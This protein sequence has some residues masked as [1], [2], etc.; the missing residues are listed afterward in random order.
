MK[1]FFSIILT[2]LLFS[3]F[4]KPNDVQHVIVMNDGK[5]K[6]GLIDSMD[7]NTV[8]Y[9][10]IDEQKQIS[11]NMQEIYYIYED[12]NKSFYFSPSLFDRLDYAEERG[13]YVIT[14]Q[15][16]TIFYNQVKFNRNLKD[17]LALLYL[18]D[19]GFSTIPLLDLHAIRVDK[20]VI[21]HSVRKGA[22]ATSAAFLI[23][24]YFHLKDSFSN[25]TNYLPNFVQTENG[26]QFQSIT[27]IF[28]V[29]TMGWMI[30]D[31]I[32]DKRTNYIRP[33]EREKQFPRSMFFFSLKRKI[34]GGLRNQW[35]QI[36]PKKHIPNILAR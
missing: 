10:D 16:D 23:S 34:K 9:F 19:G 18:R 33:L 2:I 29:T 4:G 24:V 1:H 35:K 21:E 7:Y 5:S 28:P 12:L 20:T 25:A 6:I 31:L 14:V 27:F 11:T 32:I 3:S 8:H 17:P 26:E 22:R 36:F 13:G 15:N 30:Y